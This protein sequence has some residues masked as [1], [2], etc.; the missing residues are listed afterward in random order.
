MGLKN[1]FLLVTLLALMACEKLPGPGVGIPGPGGNGF[2]PVGPPPNTPGGTPIEKWVPW[3]ADSVARFKVA[4]STLSSF[5]GRTAKKRTENSTF[6]NFSLSQRGVNN[7]CYNGWAHRRELYGGTIT[8]GF[9]VEDDEN[10]KWSEFHS[11]QTS[12][13]SVA[14]MGDNGHNGSNRYNYVFINEQYAP[15]SGETAQQAVARA[16]AANHPRLVWQGFFEDHVSAL[17]VI[18]NDIE[19]ED[20]ASDTLGGEV[21]YKKFSTPRPS[22]YLGPGVRGPNP[23]TPCWFISAGPYDCRAFVRLGQEH[24][25]SPG[26]RGNPEYRNYRSIYPNRWGYN[27]LG[28]FTGLKIE[29]AFGGDNPFT[30]SGGCRSSVAAAQK[31]SSSPVNR[32]IASLKAPS[33]S[34][35]IKSKKRKYKT[36]KPPP[37]Q[38][39]LW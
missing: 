10:Y 29:P 17:I 8:M 30:S 3:D 28:R 19:G 35:K 5:I 2:G 33:K 32:A 16:T 37:S 31:K 24:I 34:K 4:Q 12:R 26:T 21:W 20:G 23:P 22:K 18:I 13:H 38:P 39:G 9:Q 14:G 1:A 11:D 27:R 25:N 6:I 36:F 15:L 7:S